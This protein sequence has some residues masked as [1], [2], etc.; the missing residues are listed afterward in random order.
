MGRAVIALVLK[1][2]EPTRGM[3]DKAEAAIKSSLGARLKNLM[4]RPGNACGLPGSVGGLGIWLIGKI[5]D[6][7]GGTSGL[8]WGIGAAMAFCVLG[9]IFLLLAARQIAAASTPR[10]VPSRS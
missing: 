5:S 9:A 4:G 7:V 2:R 6:V 10:I 8:A 1:P 3:A